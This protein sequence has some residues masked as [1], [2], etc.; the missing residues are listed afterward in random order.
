MTLLLTPYLAL[1]SLERRDLPLTRSFR[2]AAEQNKCMLTQ[3]TQRFMRKRCSAFVDTSW[4]AWIAACHA[5]GL[6][7]HNMHGIGDIHDIH[8]MHDIHKAHAS[9]SFLT[10]MAFQPDML[11]T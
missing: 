7:D 10:V 11:H 2:A 5:W 9:H 3:L 6:C 4:S 1:V 8:D